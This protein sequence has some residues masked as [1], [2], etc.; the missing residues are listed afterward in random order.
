MSSAVES[1]AAWLAADP[2]VQAL[3]IEVRGYARRHPANVAWINLWREAFTDRRD[4][5]DYRERTHQLVVSVSWPLTSGGADLATDQASLDGLVDALVA[6][7]RASQSHGGLWLAVADDAGGDGV[8]VE[9]GDPVAAVGAG[10]DQ[11]VFTASIRYA[12]LERLA[13]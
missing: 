7:V 4:D 5:A 10:T 2:T 8:R 9:Y 11:A 13:S 3:G 1:E 12:V 6:R